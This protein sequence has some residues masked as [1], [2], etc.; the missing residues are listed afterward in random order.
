M[1]S[2]SM[3]IERALPATE[4]M[5]ASRSPALRSGIFA[6]AISSTCLLVKELKVGSRIVSHSFDMGDWEPDK[7]EEGME[8]QTIRLWIVTEKAKAAYG[9]Q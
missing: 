8:G 5:A 4:R 1:P 6:L 7:T 2:T 3:P 9:S